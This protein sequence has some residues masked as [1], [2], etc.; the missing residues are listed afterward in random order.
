MGSRREF[1]SAVST[2]ARVA[3]DTSAC[4][5]YLADSGSRADLVDALVSRAANGLVLIDLPGIVH[6]ELLVG[7]YR[8]RAQPDV[9]R[10]EKFVL[11]E[12]GIR[13]TSISRRVLMAAAEV[14]ALT[15]LKVPDALVVGAAI[16]GPC[17]A[18]VGNDDRFKRLDSIGTVKSLVSGGVL[19]MPRYLHLDDYA[20]GA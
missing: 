11:S 12:P 15:G 16:A 4:I 2:F 19:R 8:R 20:S 18:I 13:T 14:R 9:K 6:L 5:Y 7:P 1:L 3:F 10:V 17:G